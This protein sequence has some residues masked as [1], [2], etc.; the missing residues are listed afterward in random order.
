MNAARK[1]PDPPAKLEDGRVAAAEAEAGD[2]VRAALGGDEVSW[3]ALVQRYSGL[4][5]SVARGYRLGQADAADVFQ[6]TWLRL[7]EHLGRLS[8]P[9]QVGAWLA[10]TA[11]REA[12]RTAR[13]AARMAPADDATLVALGHVDHYSPEHAAL[14]AEQARLDADRAASLWRAFGGL[15]GR[16]RELLRILIA[17]PPP[18]YGEV[19]AALDM[20]VGSIGPTRARCLRRLRELLAGKVSEAAS[21]AHDDG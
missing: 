4:V 16:C 21:H 1:K 15:P 2:L 19:A 10:T 17:M 12:L 11:R 20:P 13:G 18:S 9:G 8:N 5:W 3:E 6:T 7:A 14:D